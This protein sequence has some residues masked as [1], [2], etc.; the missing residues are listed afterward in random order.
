MYKSVCKLY[1]ADTPKTSPPPGRRDTA[2]LGEGV[3]KEICT[4]LP[5]KLSGSKYQ[6]AKPSLE[7]SSTRRQELPAIRNAQ[8]AV[9][10]VVAVDAE[11]GSAETPNNERATM[12]TL[13]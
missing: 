7:D 9:G 1:G 5:L 8:D 10:I 6:E 3:L 2:D 11:A 13:V 12:L 4:P